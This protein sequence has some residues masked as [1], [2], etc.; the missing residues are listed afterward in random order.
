M[1]ALSLDLRERIAAAVEAGQAQ[2]AV[3][4]RFAVSLASVERI[5]RKRR[6]GNSLAPGKHPGK[7]PLVSTDQHQAFASL[8]AS[9][10]DWTLQ[11][12]VDAW[13]EQTGTSVSLATMSRSLRRCGFVHKKS[14]RRP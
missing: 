1:Q 5:A 6:E 4:A 2:T 7:A 8:V 3:A 12:L 14:A 10:T 11:R 9:R 13:R